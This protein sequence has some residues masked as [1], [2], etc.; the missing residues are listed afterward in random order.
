MWLPFTPREAVAMIMSYLR[1]GADPLDSL[2]CSTRGCG[3]ACS[4]DGGRAAMTA[5]AVRLQKLPKIPKKRDIE[6]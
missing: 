1:M 4:C 5:A 2:D 6:A 3:C